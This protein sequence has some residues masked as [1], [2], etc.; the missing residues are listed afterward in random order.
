[1][2]LRFTQSVGRMSSTQ[3]S[4]NRRC[5]M[6]NLKSLLS[7]VYLKENRHILRTDEHGKA[8][9][10]ENDSYF[11]AINNPENVTFVSLWDKSK[12]VAVGWMH[13][14]PGKERETKGYMVV[15]QADI[16][17]SH[18]GQKLGLEIYRQAA[19]FVGAKYLGLASENNQ[20]ENK[21]QVPAIWKRL[22]AQKVNGN[23]LLPS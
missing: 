8:I 19:R 10:W 2:T 5:L 7:R 18:R 21:K 1:M 14:A 4:F 13:L 3:A 12:Q 20:R 9:A 17:T 16:L 6:L 15:T 22:G 23:F 11:I